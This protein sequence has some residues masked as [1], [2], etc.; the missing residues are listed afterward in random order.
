MF[1]LLSS[2]LILLGCVMTEVS[3]QQQRYFKQISVEQGLP[4][5]RVQDV[6]VDDKGM[7]WIGTQGGLSRFDHYTITNYRHSSDS[8][9]LPSSYIRSVAQDA[10]GTIWV[11]TSSGVVTYNSDQDL[12]VEQKVA[13]AR[14]DTHCLLPDQHGVWIGHRDGLAYWDHTTGIINKK[15]TEKFAPIQEI[16]ALDD[17]TLLLLSRGLGV[18]T[19]S[20]ASQ[21]IKQIPFQTSGLRWCTALDEQGGLWISVYNDGIYYLEAKTYAVKKHFTSKNSGLSGDIV[22]DMLWSQGRLWCATD[23]Q[24]ISIYDPATES[25]SHIGNSP[26][27]SSSIKASSFFSLYED[28][29]G[30]V[31][32]GS[33]REGLFLIHPTFIRTFTQTLLGQ[34]TGLSHKVIISMVRDPRTGTLWVGTDGGG[35]NSFD[36]KT[37]QFNHY[38]HMWGEKISSIADFSPNELLLSSFNKGLWL[39]DKRTG[40]KRPFVIDEAQGGERHFSSGNL[41]SVVTLDNARTYIMGNT[42][43]RYDHQSKKFDNLHNPEIDYDQQQGLQVIAQRNR[44]IHLMSFR[45]ILTLDDRTGRLTTAVCL[46]ADTVFQAGAVDRHGN[47]WIGT[48]KGL[49]HY[50]TR[51]KRIETV[52][53][54]LF[55]EVTALTLDGED[56][57][58]GGGDNTL[59]CYLINEK[60]FMLFGESDGVLTGRLLSAPFAQT[61]PKHIYMGSTSGLVCVDNEIGLHH[62][63]EPKLLLLDVSVDGRSVAGIYSPTPSPRIELPHDHTSLAIKVLADEKDLFRRKRFRYRIDGHSELPITS[64]DHTLALGQLP[65]GSYTIRVSCSLDNGEWSKEAVL[66]TVVINPPWWRSWWFVLCVISSIV[67][68]LVW[69]VGHMVRTKRRKMELNLRQLERRSFQDKINYLVNI[70][71]ELRTPLTLILAPL[72]NLLRS[73]TLSAVDRKQVHHAYTHSRYMSSV[74]N[75]VLDL[76]KMETGRDSTLDWKAHSIDQWAR[77]VVDGFSIEAENR[78]ITLRLTCSLSDPMVSFDESKCKMVLSNLLMNAFKFSPDGSQ[79]D[80]DITRSSSSSVRVSVVDRGVGLDQTDTRRLFTP[81]YQGRNARQGTGIGLS[82]AKILVEQHGGTIGAES[83]QWGGATFYFELPLN[84]DLQTVEVLRPTI[85]FHTLG[86]DST[87]EH[88]RSEVLKNASVLVVDDDPDLLDYLRE[89]IGGAFGQFETASNGKEA[90]GKII[91]KGYDLVLSDVLMPE[92]DGFE[93]CRN[94]KSTIEVSHIPIILLTSQIDEATSQEGYKV[95]ADAYVGK[96]FET[97]RLLLIA[98]N[99]L[100]NRRL[101]RNRSKEQ[102]DTPSHITFSSIDEQFV[103]K[104]NELINKHLDDSSLSINFIAREMCMS[105]TS[106]YTKLNQITSLGVNQYITQIRVDRACELLLHTDKSITEISEEVGFKYPRYLSTLFREQKGLSP[107]EYRSQHSK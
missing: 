82:Y 49:L 7:V 90:L 67:G 101:V 5:P 47:L 1:R 83:N 26:L 17:H 45:S 22:L 70:S 31:W 57:L 105:R 15:G 61:D 40:S 94:I 11:A 89:A 96:P 10:K 59:F 102:L 37:G 92:G 25:F 97:D 53:S 48:D 78:F 71:H 69:L 66:A 84:I 87:W 39:F 104:L 85:D 4:H 75:M 72:K 58:W 99:I 103:V 2:I 9:S 56:R 34:S 62:T 106:L 36:P 8:T 24:G 19:Y 29:R 88:D 14:I 107:S 28:R 41:V 76:Q 73:E 12:F 63:Q 50:N 81:F 79:I 60:R 13:G 44:Q 46:G 6:L 20:I 30:N 86:G 38:P 80:I 98:T 55:S 33:I 77:E 51:L 54:D 52:G 93:L 74:I 91:S 64:Y 43:V 18:A 3:A 16:S 21:Q 42:V 95:G 65:P 68:V 35:I 27:E 32:A 23:G 100:Y